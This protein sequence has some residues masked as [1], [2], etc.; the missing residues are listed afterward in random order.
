MRIRGGAEVLSCINNRKQKPEKKKPYKNTVKT[1]KEKKVLNT[2]KFE[3]LTK[4][5][6]EQALD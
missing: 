1:N 3:Y 4:I 6:T 5:T 2:R